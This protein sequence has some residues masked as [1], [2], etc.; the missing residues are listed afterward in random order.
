[1]SVSCKCSGI[2]S[3][4][5]TDDRDDSCT[6]SV[7]A[8]SVGFGRVFLGTGKNL[9]VSDPGLGVTLTVKDAKE[10]A[11]LLVDMCLD[12]EKGLSDAERS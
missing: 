1:M 10:F 9:D 2:E 5:A 12:I 8:K 6:W 3:I 4:R 11:A 7:N